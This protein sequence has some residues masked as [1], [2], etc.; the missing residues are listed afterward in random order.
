MDTAYEWILC[1]IDIIF[2]FITWDIGYES[3]MGD[4]DIVV[5]SQHEV[6]VP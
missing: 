2:M 5:Y 6:E 3:L 1:I 4:G